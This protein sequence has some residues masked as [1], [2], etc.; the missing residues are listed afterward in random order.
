VLKLEETCVFNI[1][2]PLALES[3]KQKKFPKILK[4]SKK[5]FIL[6]KNKQAT[7]INNNATTEVVIY[8]IVLSRQVCHKVQAL[9]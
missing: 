9:T 5:R 1:A 8:I 3:K 2:R 6:K 7:C 4:D